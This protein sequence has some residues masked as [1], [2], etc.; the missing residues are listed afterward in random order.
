M[1][2]GISTAPSGV[3]FMQDTRTWIDAPSL[4]L[5]L[6]DDAVRRA[7]H[8]GVP[9]RGGGGHGQN[10]SA[11]GA[12]G[13]SGPGTSGAL[14]EGEESFYELLGVPQDASPELIKKQYYILARRWASSD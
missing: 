1:S 8:S 14:V 5:A 2:A 12:R 6:D 4:A 10:G 11:G 7:W 3:L 13:G 9:R